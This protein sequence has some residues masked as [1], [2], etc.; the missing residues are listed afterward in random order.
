[1]ESAGILLEAIFSVCTSSLGRSSSS[2]AG[3]GGMMDPLSEGGGCS[4]EV[5]LWLLGWIP[6]IGAWGAAEFERHMPTSCWR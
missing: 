3:S 2:R 6:G 1:M 5:V 4:T